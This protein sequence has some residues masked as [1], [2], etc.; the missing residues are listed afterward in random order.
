MGH[1]KSQA[2]TCRA[3]LSLPSP[4]SCSAHSSLQPRLGF[5]CLLP[6]IPVASAL[7]PCSTDLCC[8][9]WPWWHA[10]PPWGLEAADRGL[11]LSASPLLTWPCSLSSLAP[12]T[13]FE[14]MPYMGITLATI[15]TM[16][17][18]A[19]EAKMRQVIC[20]GRCLLGLPVW[21]G[22]GARSG[23]GTSWWVVC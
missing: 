21:P 17:R 1:L 10:L 11:V 19:N 16:L 22:Q 18:L 5:F 2:S 3:P 6:P 12:Y 23:T 9:P 7:L 8:F 4:T 20:G 14:F 15:F 13:V